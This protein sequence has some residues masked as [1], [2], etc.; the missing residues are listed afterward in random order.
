M[1][2][3]NAP[4]ERARLLVKALL[5]YETNQGDRITNLGV[6]WAEDGGANLLVSATKQA[7][8]HLLKDIPEFKPTAKTRDDQVRKNICESL[9]KHLN[10]FLEILDDHRTD[11][12]KG[13]GDWIFTLVLWYRGNIEENLSNLDNLWELKRSPMGLFLQS[14][15]PTSS[16]NNVKEIENQSETTMN[17]LF[18]D[19][20]YY[21][22]NQ[23]NNEFSNSRF[24]RSIEFDSECWV[25]GTSILSYFSHILKVK[26]PNQKIKVRIE[27]EDLTL[28]MIIDTPT[29]QREEIE[30]TF[31]EYGMVVIGDLKPE[32]FLDDPIEVMALKNKLE[33]AH[34][35]LRQTKELFGFARDH[36]QQ[37]IESLEVQ[38]SKLHSI[39]E[40]NL[41]S[42]NHVFGVI[43]KMSEQE[44]ATYNLSNAKFGGGFAAEGGFQ[45][46]GNL[47]D[48]SSANN[49]TEAAQ[50][51]QE[52]LQQ[53][54]SQG[55]SVED[56]TQQAASDL[57]KQAKTNPTV[58][59]KLV[60]W[61]RSLADTAGKTTVSTVT[62]NIVKLALQMIGVPLP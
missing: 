27:Q 47:I 49:L 31:K 2:K 8:F 54:Q 13:V 19:G 3:G 62:A 1:S 18:Y 36:N 28:R 52:L 26:Y 32:I 17:N 58:M 9:T 16:Q 44:R 53:L 43:S 14:A 51:I 29:G 50:Q 37:R 46:G 10:Q 23:L 6:N 12:Q 40:R 56:A 11:Q 48:L 21:H 34:L 38:L 25:A 33:M 61:G 20:N 15:D 7:L 55:T 30:K 59:G 45:V 41:H 60:Q 57:A 42:N 5:E 4:K 22:N 24:E 39:I 35:E